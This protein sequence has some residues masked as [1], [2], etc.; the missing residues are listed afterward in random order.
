MQHDSWWQSM[1]RIDR[2]F[3]QSRLVAV[4][5]AAGAAVSFLMGWTIAGGLTSLIATTAAT[6]MIFTW[7]RRDDLARTAHKMDGDRQR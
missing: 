3:Q 5:C 7:F 6:I 2:T 4:L 1:A